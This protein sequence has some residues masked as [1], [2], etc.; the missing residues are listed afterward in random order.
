MNVAEL[1]NMQAAQTKPQEPTEKAQIVVMF[2][3]IGQNVVVRFATLKK[4]EKELSKLLKAW[5]SPTTTKHH[6]I[7]GDMFSTTVDL[8]DIISVSLVDHKVA[9]KFIPR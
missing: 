4:A 3:G 5:T 9:G 6:T 2:G 1:A 8:Y 7:A